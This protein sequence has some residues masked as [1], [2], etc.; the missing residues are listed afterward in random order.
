MLIDALQVIVLFVMLH[1]NQ[2]QVIIKTEDNF[3][4]YF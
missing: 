4:R 1:I 3:C 2:E